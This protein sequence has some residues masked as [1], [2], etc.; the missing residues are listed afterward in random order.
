MGLNYKGVG[1]EGKKPVIF[2]KSPSSI[3][4]NGEYIV[5]PFGMTRVWA[6]SELAIIMGK[7]NSIR[8]YAVANDVTGENLY[9]RDHHLVQSKAADTFCPLGDE[10]EPIDITNL[11]VRTYIN[12]KIC[13]DG[14]T[15]DMIYKPENLVEY[16]LNYM[17]LDEGDV[18]LT[19]TPT[20]W[21][22]TTIKSGDEVKVC[23]E[24][25]GEVT[26]PVI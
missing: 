24:G 11:Y 7:N 14:S 21:L 17:K 8:G 19:G 5:I 13:Q 18:I 3:I 10:T 1:V 12:G 20:G 15:N 16:I 4:H 2:M 22:E 25:I 9:E 6:E 26:N 23:V